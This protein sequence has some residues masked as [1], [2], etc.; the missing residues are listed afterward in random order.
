[1]PFRVFLI[2]LESVLSLDPFVFFW[3]TSLTKLVFLLFWEREGRKT[4][5]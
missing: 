4:G 1:M 2:L 5:L 3:A